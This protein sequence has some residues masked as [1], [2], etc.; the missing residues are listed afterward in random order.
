MTFIHT[1]THTHTH[2]MKVVIYMI[3]EK[4]VGHDIRYNS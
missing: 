1:D 3:S 4:G 2:K